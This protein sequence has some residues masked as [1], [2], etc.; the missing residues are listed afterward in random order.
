MEEMIIVQNSLVLYKNRPAL[1]TRTGDKLELELADGKKLKVRLKDVTLLHPGPL[2]SLNELQPPTGE[3]KTAWELLA[4]E[5]TTLAELTELAYEVFTPA[6]AWAAWQ[7]VEDGL[8]FRGTPAEVV[9]ASAEE[10]AQELAARQAKA[11]EEQAWGEFLE[12]AGQGQFS[13]DDARFLREVEDLAL[14]RQPKSRVLRELGRAQSPENAHALLLELGYWDFAVNPYPHRL[15]LPVDPPLVEL[16]DLPD[17]ERVDLT[18]LP[19]FAIDDEGSQDPDDALSL[20]GNRLWVHVSDPAALVKPDSP[21]DLEARLRGAKLYLPEI[22]VPMLPPQATDLLGLGLTE[23]SPALSFG[24]EV[25]DNGEIGQVE[26]TPSWV[27]VTRLTYEE[28]ETRLAEEP[29]LTLYRLAQ[30][31]EARRTARGAVAIDLPEVKVRVVAGEVVIRPL[32]SLRSRDLVREAM[33]MVGEA[34]ARF[35]LAHNIPLPFTSQEKSDMEAEQLPND[36][37]G[38][39]ARRRM[40]QRSQLTSIPAPHEGLGLELYTQLT[41]P[42]RRYLDLVMHQQVR[43]FLRGEELLDSQ[44]ILERVGAAE[45]II[46]SVRQ[47]ERLSNKHWTLVYLL[48]HPDWQGEGV[49]VEKRGSRGTVLIPELD[50]I[51][52]LNMR[53]DVPLNTV[54]PLKVSQINLAELEGYFRRIG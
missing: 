51:T 19:A 39:F 50:L 10:V 48:Q 52:Y 45:S 16:P 9:A 12:R 49:L 1:V 46:G 43:A 26:V 14:E 29:F 3:V 27:R 31:H 7:L 22:R 36:I 53:E 18:H 33:L 8:Y 25:A 23:L 47:A 28:A 41:S 40:M 2:H 11:A 37:A 13:S 32:L 15:K 24:L 35:A 20:D 6:T 34:M 54:L 44:A 5:T 30:A 17:E 42:L 21:A 38:M 4:G